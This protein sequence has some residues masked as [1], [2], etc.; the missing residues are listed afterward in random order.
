MSGSTIAT[1]GTTTLTASLSGN[2]TFANVGTDSGV[3]AIEPTALSYTSGGSG[4]VISTY[5]GGNID[6]FAPGDTIA[7][8]NI[9]QDYTN[10]D[11]A[12]SSIANNAEFDA[13][14][15]KQPA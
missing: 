9:E 14:S 13:L 1:G 12:P 10:F 3:L 8:A 6:N 5:L 4:G 11:M 15:P 2:I 7:L